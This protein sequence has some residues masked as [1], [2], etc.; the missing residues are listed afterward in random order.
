M[1]YP[2]ELT[3]NHAVN[4]GISKLALDSRKLIT[5]NTEFLGL[6]PEETW[7]GDVIAVLYGCNF[8]IVL[9]R[10]ERAFKYVGEC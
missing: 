7:S 1:H 9:R 5:T 2:F 8:P 10:F 3:E 4:I 6:T